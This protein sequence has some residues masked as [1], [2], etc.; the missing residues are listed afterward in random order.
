[1]S[2]WTWGRLLGIE[3]LWIREK[4]RKDEWV[5]KILLAAE[6]EAR[7]RGAVLQRSTVGGRLPAGVLPPPR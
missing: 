4:S 1:M 2:G 3:M 7:R 6:E 5:S